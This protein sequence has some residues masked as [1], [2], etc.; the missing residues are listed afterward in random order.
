MREN[1]KEKYSQGVK[2]EVGVVSTGL[3]QVLLLF[4]L[5]G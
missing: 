3:G 2:S 4:T 5:V 1:L